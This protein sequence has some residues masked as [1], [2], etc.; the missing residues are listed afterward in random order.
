[1]TGIKSIGKK[2]GIK[3]DFKVLIVIQPA[4]LNDFVLPLP[5]YL[6]KV[7]NKSKTDKSTFEAL[8]FTHKK[9]FTP[10]IV[11]YQK[12]ETKTIR[13]KQ[14]GKNLIKTFSKL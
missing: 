5:E 6:Q 13:L 3:K 10:W 2:L 7:L 8:S 1:M 14:F 9:E 12:R 4:H 11:T